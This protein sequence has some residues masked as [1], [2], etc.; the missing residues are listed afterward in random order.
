MRFHFFLHYGCF[1]QNLG[2][3]GRRTFMHTTVAVLAMLYTELSLEEVLGPRTHQVKLQV[4]RSLS[5]WSGG[6]DR[7]EFSIMTAR[8]EAGVTWPGL[9]SLLAWS[10]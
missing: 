9:A 7:T 1:F 4:L 8:W 2:K 6:Q 10:L 5:N 3:E